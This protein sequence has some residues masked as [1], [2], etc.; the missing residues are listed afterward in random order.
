MP[1][2]RVIEIVTRVIDR[3]EAEY[4]LKMKA[5]IAE[6][7]RQTLYQIGMAVDDPI[8]MQ[9]DFSVL[10][11]LRKI[12]YWGAAAIAGGGVTVVV[13]LILVALK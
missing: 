11:N 8:Q 9:R 12:F 3:R 6:T 13:G 4:E 7:V 1:E 10:R 2:S 5:Y